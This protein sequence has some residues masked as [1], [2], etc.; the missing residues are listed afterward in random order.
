MIKENSVS[1][2]NS[3]VDVSTIEKCQELIAHQVVKIAELEEQLAN[4]IR[5][6]F[7]VGDYFIEHWDKETNIYQYQGNKHFKCLNKKQG[8]HC[9]YIILGALLLEEYFIK[10]I[11]KEEAEAKLKELRGE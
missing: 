6:K 5:P 7:K 1:K 3:F 4:S 2:E 11:S 9:D 8:Y 10:Q